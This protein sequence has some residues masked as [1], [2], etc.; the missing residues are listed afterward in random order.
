MLI[1][2]SS[3]NPLFGQKRDSLY[4]SDSSILKEVVFQVNDSLIKRFKFSPKG[5]RYSIEHESTAFACTYSILTDTLFNE[6]NG[7]LRATVEHQIKRLSQSKSCD[8]L[9]QISNIRL[10]QKGE[11]QSI[12]RIKKIGSYAPCPCGEWKYYEHNLPVFDSTFASCQSRYLNNLTL[13]K[14]FWSP[15]SNYLLELYREDLFIVMPGQGSDH[16]ATLVLKS[17]SGEVIKVV[18]SDASN[19]ALHRDIHTI[20]WDLDKNSLW[21][22]RS[23][24]IEWINE[25]SVDLE[26]MRAK[27]NGFMGTTK[28]DYFNIPSVFGD[29]SYIIGEFYGEPEY[30]RTLDVVVLIQDSMGS[31]KM[32]IVDHYNYDGLEQFDFIEFEHLEDFGW[33]G[34]FK[35]VRKGSPIWSNWV[36]GG[37]DEGHRT[38]EEVPNNEVEYLSY[39]AISIHAGESCGGG[40]IFWKENRWNWLQQE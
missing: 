35:A 30:D 20:R 6:S 18:S 39:D 24:N 14:V 13:T 15:D 32:L 34:H 36:D 8:S 31:V 29:R 7:V 5:I 26:K 16:G 3:A 37:N 23:S 28:W 22:N 11:L 12:N 21:Y 25:E 40:F 33:I 10:Y 4:W 17:K 9:I 1:Y 27:I 19:S 38:F 2:L